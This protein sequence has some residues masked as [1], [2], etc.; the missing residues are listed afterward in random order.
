LIEKAIEWPTMQL[1]FHFFV[2]P[3]TCVDFCY[4]NHLSSSG[5]YFDFDSEVGFYTEMQFYP[6]RSGTDDSPEIPPA[7]LQSYF[8]LDFNKNLVD[9]NTLNYYLS[10]R[11]LLLKKA[12][13][14]APIPLEG[15][16]IQQA[17]PQGLENLVQWIGGNQRELDANAVDQMLHT[18]TPIL[19][20]DEKVLMAFKAGRDTSVFTNLR[21]ICIDVQGLTGLKIEYSSLPYHSIRSWSI[22]TAGKRKD[23]YIATCVH[24]INPLT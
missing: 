10:R 18:S 13:V 1:F 4:D 6:G 7:P 22:E 16:T 8:E 20:D 5:K 17:E 19:L 23:I 2:S 3:I 11:L 21:V 24:F 9:M 12:E 15:M 14:G